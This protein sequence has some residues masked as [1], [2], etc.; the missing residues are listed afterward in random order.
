MPPVQPG[1]DPA[2]KG[3]GMTGQHGADHLVDRVVGRGGPLSH[4]SQ[5]RPRLASSSLWAFRC[6]SGNL[7]RICNSAASDDCFDGHGRGWTRDAAMVSAIAEALE[8]YA[9]CVAGAGSQIHFGPAGEL[10]GKAVAPE[11]FVRMSAKEREDLGIDAAPADSHS[12]MGWYPG[13][14]LAGGRSV[15]LPAQ[16]AFLGYNV[17]AFEAQIQFATTKGLSAHWSDDAAIL[18]A[19]CEVIEADAFMITYLNRLPVAEIDLCTVD[20]PHIR[21]MLARAE[22]GDIDFLRAWDLTTDCRVPTVLAALGGSLYDGPVVTFGSATAPD[23]VAAVSKAVQEAIHATAWLGSS[24]V[25][26]ARQ[27]GSD[28]I[29][30]VIGRAWHKTLGTIPSY[31]GQLDWLLSRRDRISIDSLPRLPGSTAAEQLAAVVEGVHAAGMSCYACDL[32]PPDLA[33]A[34]G[35]R[36]WRV[37]APEAQP[38]TLAPVRYLDGQRLRDVPVRLG[39]RTEP[40]PESAFN[41]VPHPC[42]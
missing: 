40:L 17:E 13:H 32:T 34:T 31:L 7:R 16:L 27:W 22:D 29:G 11:R 4:L 28:D 9:A 42:P 5:D 1:R 26:T 37:L 2:A 23:P 25:E 33:D 15:L 24:L 10:N 14:D 8:R 30:R 19:L 6:V 36:V 21:A 39:Y 18:H 12:R 3:D 35:M 20:D 41:P 38:F